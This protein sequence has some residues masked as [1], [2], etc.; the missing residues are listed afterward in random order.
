MRIWQ[1]AMTQLY[2]QLLIF[3]L[4]RAFWYL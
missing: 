2:N 1:Y 3:I 4:Y